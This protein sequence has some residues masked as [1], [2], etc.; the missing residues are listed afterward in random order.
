MDNGYGR[1]QRRDSTKSPKAAPKEPEKYTGKGG[2]I[3]WDTYMIG[4]RVAPS[5]AAPRNRAN[6][7]R[8]RINLS[9]L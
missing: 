5:D 7:I 6:R 2:D 3:V 4:A 8:D 9:N 1:S